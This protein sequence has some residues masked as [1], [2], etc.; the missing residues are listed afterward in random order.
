[1][2]T[3]LVSGA[4]GIV[5]YGILK[6]L[7]GLGFRLIGTTIYEE[8]VAPAFCDIFEPA[9]RTDAP[10][11]IDWLKEIIKKYNVDMIIP[12]IEADVATWNK[13]RQSLKETGTFALL[14]APQL[15]E[16]CADKWAFYE[17]LHEYDSRYVIPTSLEPDFNRFKRPFLL[18][19]RNGFA[20]RGLITVENRETFD[21]HKDKIGKTLMMQSI[22]GNSDEEYTTSACFDRDSVLRA[23]RT[24]RRRLSDDG[25][26]DKA[27]V[28]DLEG[29]ETAIKDISKVFAPV[30]PTNLQFRKTSKG[31][32][33]LEINPRISSST[34]IRTAF[35]YN[36][37][38]MSVDYFLYGK[39][40][41][42][43]EIQKGHVIRYTEDMVFHDRAAL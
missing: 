29:V 7:K 17:K 20:S 41:T 18:K 15:I 3:I 1:M 21:Q 4:S 40:I 25:F 32:K 2:K 14:N 9:V 43:P 19:P 42:Q 36:E 13:H 31:L 37:A 23:H 8:S 39:E 12:S 33:L 24:L 16:L 22:A 35:G 26:T 30:G 38:R 10:D 5:G 27:F 11:Y 34:S 6:S 28:A